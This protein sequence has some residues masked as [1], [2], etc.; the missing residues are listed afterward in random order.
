MRI[1]IGNC[2]ETNRRLA[3]AMELTAKS[4]AKMATEKM[5]RKANAAEVVSQKCPRRQL[6]RKCAHFPWTQRMPQWPPAT[7]A[8]IGEK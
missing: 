3:L 2:I 1:N 8:E 7:M 6:A 4:E 5:E